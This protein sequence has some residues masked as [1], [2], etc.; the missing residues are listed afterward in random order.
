MLTSLSIGLV[1]YLLGDLSARLGI[2]G[3]YTIFI[4]IVFMGI[5]YHLYLCCSR[6][7]ASLE[8]NKQEKSVY[9]NEQT[10]GI[11]WGAVLGVTI[12]GLTHWT[13]ICCTCWSFEFSAYA[14]VNQGVIASL[15][16]SG[17]VFTALLFYLVYG[18]KLGIQSVVGMVF[19]VLGVVLISVSK[20]PETQEDEAIEEGPELT[21]YDQQKYLLLSVVFALI[22]GLLFS[23]NSFVMKYYPKKY[24]F[25]VIQLNLDGYLICSIFLAI[26]F[27]IKGASTYSGVD[28]LK[29]IGASVLSLIGTA[30]MT[31]AFKSGKGGPI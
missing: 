22:C 4:G 3:S 20:V 26:G 21:E 19:I 18:E 6:L 14:N 24:G 2:A 1:N 11:N 13:L 8:G 23:I 16:T 7:I 25:S 30:S 31:Q 27:F 28:I 5:L 15:F 9:H 17:V 29:A 12:R 10:D